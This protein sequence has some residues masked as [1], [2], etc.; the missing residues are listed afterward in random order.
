M[1]NFI[2]TQ[3]S[4]ANQTRVLAL[5]F[6][7]LRASLGK[8]FIAVFTPIVKGINW[9]LANL[10]PLA[11]SFASLMEMLTGSSGTTGG[12]GSALAETSTDLSSATDAA[13]SLE[14]GCRI[15]A[16]KVSLQRRK[17]RKLL[18]V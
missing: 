5:R 18:L 8:G 10:Q 12:G 15:P 16:K 9:V 13:D 6:D 3:D 7:A 4:W 14:V 1:E 2:R 11:D 17:S